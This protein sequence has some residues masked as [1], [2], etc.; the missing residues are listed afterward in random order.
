M[1]F[2]K[3]IAVHKLHDEKVK[4][5]KKVAEDSN[6]EKVV[7]NPEDLNKNVSENSTLC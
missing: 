7:K 6:K 4:I 5:D 3:V 2:V 1:S